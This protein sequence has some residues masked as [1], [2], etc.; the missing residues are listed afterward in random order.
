MFKNNENITQRQPYETAT[1][2]GQCLKQWK[3]S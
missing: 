3:L 1:G 2:L